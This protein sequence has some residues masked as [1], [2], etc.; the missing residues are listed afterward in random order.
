MVNISGETKLFGLLGQ[1]VHR[2]LSPAMH[3]YAAQLFHKDLVYLNFD[4]SAD[5]VAHFLDVFWHLGGQGLNVTMPHKNL[6]ADL[7]E[8]NGLKSVNTLVRTISGWSGHST[9][10]DGFLRGLER[11]NAS[12]TDFDMVIILGNGGAAQAVLAAVTCSTVDRPLPFVIHRRSPINDSRMFVSASEVVVQ[13]LTF[14]DLSP[15]S[16]IDTMKC[17]AGLRRLIIQATSAPKQGDSMKDLIPALDYMSQEDLLVDLIYD[18]PSDL[19]FA[20]VARGLRCQ[21]GLPMLIEQ[22]RLSQHLWWGKAAI[23]DDMVAG[24]KKSGGKG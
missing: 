17:S 8:S 7:V 13:M 15:A 4:L 21:D 18:K 3:N 20:A 14:R 2:T 23:Y 22:A 5:K 1:G 11:I 12:L 16:F 24:I 10:G 9:D 6:A 19:Y